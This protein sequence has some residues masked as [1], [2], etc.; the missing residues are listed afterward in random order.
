MG[1]FDRARH[2]QTLDPIADCEEIFTLITR[3][4]FPWDYQFAFGL[5]VLTDLAIPAISGLLHHTGRFATD[6]IKRAEDTLLFEYEAK[7]AGLDSPHGRQAIRALNRIHGRY[8]ISNDDYLF[9]LAAWT[10][11]PIRFINA[12][13]WRQLTTAEVTAMIEADRRM[14]RLMGVKD[15]PDDYHGFVRLLERQLCDRARVTETGQ[16]MAETIVGVLRSFTPR[17]LRPFARQTVLALTD[18]RVRRLLGLPDPKRGITTL[19]HTLMRL[20]GHLIRRLPPR[21]DSRPYTPR[22]RSYP[23]GWTID[24]LGPR[25]HP[26]Y[27]DHAAPKRPDG[28]Q[29][30]PAEPCLSTRP[31]KEDSAT[32]TASRRSSSDDGPS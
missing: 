17:S 25:R 7:R 9:V 16:A 29:G 10:L 15:I 14:G 8:D 1:R 18:P 13:G 23:L 30:A 24:Q 12:Y 6:G 3:Y 21:P 11:G 31:R 28:D 2:I 22:P 27:H 26:R 5:T 4:E 20:R 19:V 32:A